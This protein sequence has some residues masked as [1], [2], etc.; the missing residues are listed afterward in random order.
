MCTPSC[1]SSDTAYLAPCFAVWETRLGPLPPHPRVFVIRHLIQ[2]LMRRVCLPHTPSGR[3]CLNEHLS[4]GV[5]LRG[6]IVNRIYGTHTNTYI[7]P[8]FF[9]HF[10]VL[11]AMVHRNNALRCRRQP[12]RLTWGSHTPHAYVSLFQQSLALCST[13]WLTPNAYETEEIRL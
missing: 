7:F 13:L 10:L 1:I 8:N 11:F 5:L 9:Q 12:C 6:T 4:G 3:P 2:K